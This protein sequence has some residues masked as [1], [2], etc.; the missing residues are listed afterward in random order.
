MQTKFGN[1]MP[2]FKMAQGTSQDIVSLDSCKEDVTAVRHQWSYVFL[3]LTHRYRVNTSRPGHFY[4]Q[5]FIM[6]F[7]EM[8]LFG[9]IKKRSENG[10]K[11][12]N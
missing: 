10:L 3:A 2:I 11:M 6:R 5:Q 4:R 1:N 12:A 8:Q 7:H 9:F